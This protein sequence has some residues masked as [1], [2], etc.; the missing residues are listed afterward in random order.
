MEIVYKERSNDI[1]KQKLS[2][3]IKMGILLQY[4]H[5]NDPEY[6]PIFT[7]PYTRENLRYAE[8]LCSYT[9]N[10]SDLYQ[11]SHR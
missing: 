8:Y 7:R 10:V 5:D 3:N 9:T 6:I 2:L 1:K 11:Y 4:L